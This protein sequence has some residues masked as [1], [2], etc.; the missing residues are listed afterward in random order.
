[1]DFSWTPE[2]DAYKRAVVDFAKDNLNDEVIDRDRRGELSLDNWRK[3]AEF[4][5]LG[6]PVSEATPPKQGR[7][8]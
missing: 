1:M 5:I 7:L 8:F 6:L 3:C 4:G 2:Q